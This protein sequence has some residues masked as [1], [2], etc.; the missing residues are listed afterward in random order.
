MENPQGIVKPTHKSWR[1][2]DTIAHA[3]L[4]LKG[5]RVRYQDYILY[6]SYLGADFGV[7]RVILQNSTFLEARAVRT[8]GKSHPLK[9]GAK[10]P[11]PCLRPHPGLPPCPPR[12]LE[13]LGFH[14]SS[15]GPCISFSLRKSRPRDLTQPLHLRAFPMGVDSLLEDCLQLPLGLS[16]E[17]RKSSSVTCGILVA[18]VDCPA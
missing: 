9:P 15:W 8:L 4:H 1:F 14:E 17:H 3:K 13:Q 16:L 6:W 7:T 18:G 12:P 11:R 2:Q 10:S 5:L